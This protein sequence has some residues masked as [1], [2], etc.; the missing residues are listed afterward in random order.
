MFEPLTENELHH[1]ARMF[2]EAS[3]R[4]YREAM[5]AAQ[6]CLHQGDFIALRNTHHDIAWLHADVAA[7]IYH[8]SN[9]KAGV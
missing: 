6:S 7:E 1:L 9:Q 5:V 2:N 4:C 3:E 8:K